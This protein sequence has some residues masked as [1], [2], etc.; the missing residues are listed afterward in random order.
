MRL[1][2]SLFR[3]EAVQA[4]T[5]RYGT[6]IRTY[7]VTSW[8]LTIFLLSLVAA[9]VLFVCVAR[10]SRKE[11][12][13]GSL[14]PTV[15]AQ[16]LVAT[17][18][19]VVDEILVGEGQEVQ[20]GTPI[21]SLSFEALSSSGQSLT[22][23][24]RRASD[25]SA[26]ALTQQ[27]TATISALNSQ[28]DELDLRAKGITA[29]LE[30]LNADEDI[31][32][33][34]IRLATEALTAAQSLHARELMATTQLRQREEAL[35]VA[36]QAQSAL[37]REQRG[38]QSQLGQHVAQRARLVAERAQA[39]ASNAQRR[40]EQSDRRT[41]LMAQEGQLLSA[42]RAGRL[43]S[44]LVRPGAS[45]QAGQTL[46]VVLPAGTELEAELW[47]PSRAVGFLRREGKVRLLYDAFPYQRF[48]A[49]EGRLR[50]IS[51]AP[52]NPGDTAELTGA[53]EPMYRVVV[54]LDRQSVMAGNRPVRLTPGM[55]LT[56]DL[57]LDER[58]LIIWLLDPL[59]STHM[60]GR[61]NSTPDA[62]AQ[63]Q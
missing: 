33:D 53:P 59:L 31:T 3:D 26:E 54:T 16:A 10:Y 11:T 27:Q 30:Q 46:G 62:A 49:Y 14:V 25:E 63:P 60:R 1:P 4:S 17:R 41:E 37:R 20:A 2:G 32:A 50:Y 48:G 34:R 12:V 8:V 61:R 55:R 13:T 15:G 47:V 51:Q 24:R 52:A 45:V 5:N 56:A 9:L 22:D 18:P 19:G 35:L 42:R 39:A 43:A 7:G 40:A 23:L 38:L 21:L 57:V 29:D 36:R 6:P 58:P 28:I 44:L